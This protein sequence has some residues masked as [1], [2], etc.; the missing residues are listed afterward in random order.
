MLL[1]KNKE[2]QENQYTNVKEK[3]DEGDLG[4]PRPKDLDWK[5]HLKK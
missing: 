1:K 4:Y 2:T 5:P 3:K